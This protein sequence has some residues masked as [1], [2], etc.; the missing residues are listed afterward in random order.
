MKEIENTMTN[1]ETLKGTKDTLPS[2]Q[3]KIN[4][5]LKVITKNFEKYGFRPFDTPLIEYLETLTNKY[6]DDAEIVQE[7]FK[8]T[9]RGD[10]K[11]GLRYD[12]TI[13]LCRFIASQKQLK[14]PFKRYAIGK[15]FRDGPIRVGRQREFMQCDA[16]V[17][18]VKGQESEAETLKMFFDTYKELGIKSVLEINNNKILRGA[19]LQEG[20]KEK[21]LDSL[22][23]SVDKLKK[24]GEKGVI[25]EIEKKGFKI[26]EAKKVISILTSKDF[27]EIRKIAKNELLIEGI[28]ELEKLAKLLKK[29]KVD[30]R[31]N[32][33]MSRGLNYYTG[34]IWEMYKQDLSSKADEVTSS[35][36]SGGR[37]DKGI[38][39]YI[40]DG[41]E[42]PAYGV[43]F[44]IV[45]IF[46]CLNNGEEKISNTQVI[47]APLDENLIEIA[48]KIANDLRKTQNVEICYDYKLKKAFDYAEY[49]GAKEI[50]IIGQKGVEKGVYTLR[51]LV[52]KKEKEVKI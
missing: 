19:F 10:R 25:D 43:S 2:E 38:G 17:I 44:G 52:S 11:L 9:D 5:I 35:I 29:L 46:A 26:N 16:D 32:F 41:R 3:L 34:N 33:S 50:A 21:D 30:F 14:L 49:V 51:N 23:L 42:Y 8:V 45:P 37:Y 40:D 31:I 13:P 12:L 6:D 22:I 39:N 7:I 28:D 24:I 1:F 27:K 20:F 15:V 47:V 48:L 18:G 36:G 4:E